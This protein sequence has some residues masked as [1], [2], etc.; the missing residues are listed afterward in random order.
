MPA[1]AC[2]GLCP[3]SSVDCHRR[4]SRGGICHSPS[5]PRRSRHCPLVPPSRKWSGRGG[6]ARVARSQASG[7]G[8]AG[9][10]LIHPGRLVP[11]L[12]SARGLGRLP[13]LAARCG[14]RNAGE[15]EARAPCPQA[16]RDVAR[17]TVQHDAP[18]RRRSAWPPATRLRRRPATRRASAVARRRR[19]VL[20][21]RTMSACGCRCISLSRFANFSHHGFS[22]ALSSLRRGLRGRSRAPCGRA[23]SS[24]P[25]TR[26]CAPGA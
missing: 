20:S 3:H 11:A 2:V 23:L 16:L 25:F 12:S 26:V 9:R 22:V 5:G 10:V 21:T 14:S 17:M 15:R 7:P 19:F 13:A 1:S 8:C 18:A 6:N 24:L 4:A